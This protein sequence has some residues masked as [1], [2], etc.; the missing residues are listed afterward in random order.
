MWWSKKWIKKNRGVSSKTLLILDS[1][2]SKDLK[3]VVFVLIDYPPGANTR[4][5]SP[6]QVLQGGPCR[7]MPLATVV[8]LVDW[9][10][11]VWILVRVPGRSEGGT[12][13]NRTEG[14]FSC[15]S[16][17]V[18]DLSEIYGGE[19]VMAADK[20]REELRGVFSYSIAHFRSWRG[21][22]SSWIWVYT[23]AIW[24]GFEINS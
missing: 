15:Y 11:L 16:T 17:G 6:I 7:Q 1:T 4:P 23:G 2:A 5:A 10:C 22:F 18:R 24:A 19:L 3:N 8:R 20:S 14:V 21:L 9:G 12:R 13:G